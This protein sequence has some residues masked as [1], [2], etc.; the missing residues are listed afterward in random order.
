MGLDTTIQELLARL[1]QFTA[2]N[3]TRC[4][5]NPPATMSDI[6]A[7]ETSLNMMLPSSYRQFLL[8]F[9]GGFISL[10][11]EATDPSWERETA[12][13]NSNHLL[14]V[15]AL[16]EAYTAMRDN[17]QLDHQWPGMWPFLPFCH[18][19][20]QEFLVFG[21]VDPVTQESPVLDAFHELWPHEWRILYPD[22]S[23]LLQNYIVQEG[24]LRLVPG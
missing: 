4:C 2:T 3:P 23:V 1:A 17:W 6:A 21:P 15:E 16:A 18:T 20:G 8:R 11:W 14:G 9:N 12:A 24:H 10:D 22:F 19:E 7:V 13:W 5:F